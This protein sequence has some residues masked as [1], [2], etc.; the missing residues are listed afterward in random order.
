VGSGHG[1]REK[2]IKL[3]THYKSLADFMKVD[4]F[5]AGR[6]ILTDGLDGIHFSAQ[7]NVDLGNALADKV[8]EILSRTGR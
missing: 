1:G 3:A 2:T 4:F 5:D 8:L 7:N 6:A